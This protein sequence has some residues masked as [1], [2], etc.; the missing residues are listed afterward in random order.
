MANTRLSAGQLRWNVRP[1]LLENLD[2][3]EAPIAIGSD[4]AI[5]ALASALRGSDGDQPHLFLRGRPG[6]GRRRLIERVLDQR[7][8]PR[9][10]GTDRVYVFNFDH[11]HQPRLL[12]L[13]A[14]QGRRLRA[15]MR[16]VIRFLRDQLE[17]AL[18]ARPIRNRLQALTDRADAEMRKI[19][20]PL[21]ERFR[22][23][24]LVLVREEVG[25]LVRLTVHVKQTGRVISQDDLANLV[26][27]G[28]VD[29]EEY[30]S[31]REVIHTEQDELA[32]ITTR[33]NEIWRRVQDLGTR[34]VQTEARRLLAGLMRSV[35]ESFELPAVSHYLN[36]VMDDV[37]EHG[38]GGGRIGELDL[39]GRYSVNLVM[40]VDPN[41]TAPVVVEPHPNARNLF[42]SIDADATGRAS[43]RGLRA[44]RLLQ[45]SGGLLVLDAD[46]LLE[47][48]DCVHRLQRTLVGGELTLEALDRGA[49]G[50]SLKP[51]P[52]PVEFQLALIGS[53]E[54][55]RTLNQRHPELARSIDQV[56]DLPDRVE[57]DQA[58]VRALGAL[59]QAECARYELPPP[60]PEALARLVEEAA[61]LDG[62][63]GL[64]TSIDRLVARARAASRIARER[65]ETRLDA[66]HVEAAIERAMV[67]TTRL[68]GAGPATGPGRFPARQPLPGQAWTVALREDGARGSGRLVR[69]QAAV[70]RADDT[71]ITLPDRVDEG[72]DRIEALL[73]TLLELDRPPRL[74]AVLDA[75]AADPHDR[76]PAPGDGFALTGLCAL[77][78][79]LTGDGLRQDV[80]LIGRVDLFGRILPVDGLNDRIETLFELTRLD[81]RGVPPTV[82]IPAAQ[83][84]ELML[85]P[86]LVQAAANDLFQVQAIGTVA[87]AL[88]LLAGHHPGKSLDGRFPDGSMFARARQ[89]LGA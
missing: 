33:V 4:A 13:P 73:G 51:D 23:H 52:I 3:A 66:D 63:G 50:A 78:S 64:S 9:A 44:G 10:D 68:F 76:D 43:F 58:H 84:D 62:R 61:R 79:R 1:D 25:R 42:G 69:I 85:S 57:R 8:T 46:V 2:T 70:T 32:R 49:P 30:R 17:P 88:D 29:R 34:L 16:Q 87:Q 71:R 81:D 11:P 26:A 45:A 72:P 60:R 37:L 28:Q 15:E 38:V 82:V 19:T 48:P 18:E 65:G 14:G 7:Q 5:D 27:K 59:L 39:E 31:I 83:R 24:G 56:I 53:A 20:D 6:S 75:H 40:A 35:D 36:A 54:A 86:R 41:G 12:E 47:H 80:A 21:D 22:P 74:H 55:W 89:R 77:V 67:S